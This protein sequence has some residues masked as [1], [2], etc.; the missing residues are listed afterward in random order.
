MTALYSSRKLCPSC[1]KPVTAVPDDVGE[2]RQRYVCLACQDDP[3]RDPAAR[4]WADSPLRPPA[5]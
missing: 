2:R 4:K 5:K 3:L 1:G